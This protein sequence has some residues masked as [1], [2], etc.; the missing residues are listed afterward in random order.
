MSLGKVEHRGKEYPHD[1]SGKPSHSQ[2]VDIFTDDIVE[3]GKCLGN[4][5]KRRFNLSAKYESNINKSITL[6]YVLPLCSAQTS[7]DGEAGDTV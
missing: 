6:T 7:I 1:S 2:D 4:F 5:G 3:R